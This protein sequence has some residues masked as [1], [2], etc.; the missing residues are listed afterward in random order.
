MNATGLVVLAVAGWLCWRVA[1][2]VTRTQQRWYWWRLGF[3]ATVRRTAV[4]LVV[5]LV[6]LAIITR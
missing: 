4:Y 5:V 6:A 1:A 3:S 2:G